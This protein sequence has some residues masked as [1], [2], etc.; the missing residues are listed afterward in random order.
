[1]KQFSFLLC[2]LFIFCCFA[3]NAQTFSDDFSDGD[4]TNNPTW[5]GDV[6]NFEILDGE[7]HLLADGEGES[8]LVSAVTQQAGVATTWEFDFNLDF[9]PS[10]G[11][12]A[13]V[14]LQTNSANLA[15][16]PEGYYIL[17]GEGGSEDAVKLYKR[18]GSSN[19]LLIE[20]NAG[21]IASSPSGKIRV[22]RS[23]EGEWELFYDLDA[24]GLN[25]YGTAIDTEFASGNFIGVWCDYTSSNADAF[26]FDNFLVDPIFIDTENPS[27]ESAV[28]VSDNEVQLI[29]SEL[30][31]ASAEDISSYS[32]NGNNIISA[33]LSADGTTVNLVFENSFPIGEQ[34]SVDFTVSDTAGNGFSG[35]ATFTYNPTGAFDVLITEIMSD[36]SPTV[37][38]PDQEYIELYNRSENAINLKDWKFLDASTTELILPS[39]ELAAGAYVTLTEQSFAYDAMGIDYIPVNLQSLTNDG[40]LL[41]LVDNQGNTIFSV[42]FNVNWHVSNKRDG[43]WSLEMINPNNPCGGAEN[44]ASSLSSK[45]GTPSEQNT[46]FDNTVS[47]TEAPQLVRVGYINEATVQAYFNEV[48]DISKLTTSNFAIDNGIGEP[49]LI[50]VVEP[51]NN[52]VILSLNNLINP[53]TT[54]TLTVTNICDCVGNIISSDN[55]SLFSIP[56]LPDSADL[57]INEILFNQATGNTDYVEIYNNSD[58]V[59]DLQNYRFTRDGYETVEGETIFENNPLEVKISESSY[60]LFPQEYLVL[61]ASQFLVKQQYFTENPNAFLDV[62]GFPTMDD[63]Q[64]AIFVK[65]S[66]GNIL[67]KVLY[68][69]NWHYDLIDSE[70]GVSLERINFDAPSQQA[71]NWHSASA[72]VGYG[73]PGYLNS[74]FYQLPELDDSFSISP[75]V[76]S[77]DGD[78]FN[79]FLL[80]N[81]EMDSEG[82]TMNVHIFDDRGREVNHLVKNE[83]L[84]RNGSYKWEGTNENGEKVNIGIYILYIE[85]FDLTGKVER[86]KRTCTV[87]GQLD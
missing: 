79:D 14:Y 3:L 25:S 77:P 54:Y 60:L 45:G 74:Q 78:S 4:F 83:L 68:T 27:F 42:D 1:M 80:L 53:G 48:I 38:L 84:G 50:T 20:G 63:S 10:G 75:E 23:A 12:R 69:K 18:S 58:K 64:D 9:N 61:S 62:A 41:Q 46:V 81:Y 76:F 44:W 8:T 2:T 13:R 30:L 59:L 5:S 21:D 66:L 72:S 40:E 86:F 35:T 32:I 70:D 39:Y 16:N 71:A 6:A 49:L 22:T 43:G 34:Q 55:F 37:G 47:D 7:L 31:D 17:L 87:A 36:P 24:S 82:F 11:N 57:I 33:T 26:Y 29:F 73:T 56:V 15:G 28:V 19:E 85:I 65:D 67:D 51:D 52:S